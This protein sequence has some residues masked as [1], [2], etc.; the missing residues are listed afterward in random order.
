[1]L[2]TCAASSFYVHCELLTRF[3]ALRR[4]Q[5]QGK[6]PAAAPRNESQARPQALLLMNSN[7]FRQFWK[8]AFCLSVGILLTNLSFVVPQKNKTP[9]TV[10]TT[11]LLTRTSSRRETRRFGYGGTVTIVGAP[12]GSIT[13]E[14]WNKSEVDISADIELQGS[15]EED[16]ERLA[17]VNNFVFDED[18]NHLSLITTGTHDKTFMKRVAKDFPRRLIGLPWKI[19]YR[20]RVPA[21]TDLEVNAGDGAI[22]LSG[23]EGAIR[24]NGR[25]TDA[26]LTLTG[27]TVSVTVATGTINVNL[28]ARSWRGAGLEVQL[29]AGELN[30]EMPA[31]FNGDID[32][33]VL[34][35]GKI[36]NSYP[37]LA[38]RE[39]PGMTPRTIRARAGAGGAKLKFAVVDGAITIKKRSGE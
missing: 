10:P 30:V 5:L 37:D 1:M 2:L 6:M 11:T 18:A 33:D 36:D 16:L 20:L 4:A 26:L 29:A 17:T 39:R 9:P 8:N 19:D 32:A 38:V 13:V 24:V 27:G 35:T 23:V 3:V 15:S 34:R 28:P 14:G 22:K 31:G 21:A 12:R 7:A 25:Q